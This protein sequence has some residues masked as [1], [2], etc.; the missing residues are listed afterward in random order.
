M[1]KYEALR[2]QMQQEGP[3]DECEHGIPESVTCCDCEA[4][5]YNR[6]LCKME[7]EI[8]DLEATVTRQREALKEIRGLFGSINFSS[9]E[10]T[11]YEQHLEAALNDIYEIAK[12]GR[13][14][15]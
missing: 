13:E 10:G 4:Q 2:D 8:A 5:K 7:D 1:S 14:A 9:D 15:P 11:D 3:E 12:I 6:D